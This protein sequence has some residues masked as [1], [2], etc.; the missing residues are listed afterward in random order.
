[1]NV[2]S[3]IAAAASGVIS[4]GNG[5]G[6]FSGALGGIIIGALSA[7]VVLAGIAASLSALLD[8]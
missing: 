7:L 2:D 8:V 3:R 6:S 4:Y 1:M 5:S